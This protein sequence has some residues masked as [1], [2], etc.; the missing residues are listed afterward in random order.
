[1]IVFWAAISGPVRVAA[2]VTWSL[3]AAMASNSGS[4]GS[5]EKFKVT[6]S[7]IASIG[8][9]PSPRIVPASIWIA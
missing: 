6:S 7:V 1:M 9:P 3:I 5:V 8:A 4:P 2:P